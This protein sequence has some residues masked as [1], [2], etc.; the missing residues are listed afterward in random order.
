MEIPPSIELDGRQL[1]R[2]L[3][4][5]GFFRMLFD[6]LP[7][8][9]VV[10]ST[11]PESF[12]EFLLWNRVAEEW[13][14]FKAAD[15]IG[16]SDYDLFPKDCADFFLEM[17]RAVVASRQTLEIPE[18][19]ILSHTRGERYLHTI[20][21]PIFDDQG[22]PLALLVVSA[23]ITEKKRAITNLDKALLEMRNERN[24]FR[25]LLDNLPVCAFAKSARPESFGKYILWNR[26]AAELHGKSADEVLGQTSEDVYPSSL[27]KAAISQDE[28][29]LETR[30]PLDVPL[31]AVESK[32]HGTRWMHITKAPVFDDRGELV[33]IIG[34]SEDITE[35]M[36]SEAERARTT[37]VLRHL[38][39]RVPGAIYQFRM[40]A[41]GS[42]G[43][44][45][46]SERIEE[47]YGIPREE[48]LRDV[49]ASWHSVV[50]EDAPLVQ[51][52]LHAAQE[53]G[54]SFQCEF[55]IR[56]RD[57]SIRWV[58]SS[59]SPHKEAG[60]L[61][62]NGFIMDVTERKESEA[63][64]RERD[65][66]WELAL[67]G[68]EAGVWDW[69]I[70]TGELF[71][72]ERWKQLFGYESSELPA[73]PQ[74][75]LELIHPDD[76][77]EVRRGMLRHLRGRTEIFRSEYRMLTTSGNYVWILAHAK[78]HFG[79][80]GEPRRLIGT[81]IDITARKQAEQLLQIAK[82]AAEEA[83]RAKGNFLAMMSHEIRTPLN[84]VL[85]FAELLAETQLDEAQSEH[86]RTIRESGASL[87]RVL[88][89]ILDY[90]KIESGKLSIEKEEVDLRELVRSAVETF[91]VLA[92]EK[93]IS[94]TWTVA[95]DVPNVVTSDNLRLHQI[96][97][98]LVSNAVKF[99]QKGGV[100]VSLDLRAMQARGAALRFTISDTGIGIAEEHLPDLFNPFQQVDVSMARRFGG[101]GLGLTIVHRLVSML[102]GNIEVKSKVGE[103]TTFIVEVMLP[104]AA[105]P[106]DTQRLPSTRVAKS[107]GP[108]DLAILL[109]EDNVVN[110]RLARLMLER[111]G[112]QPDEAEDGAAAV[113]AAAR[114]RY[115]LILM[116]IQM[117]GMDGYQAAT[118][119][120]ANCNGHPPCIVALTA[121][122]MPSDRE[123]SAAHGM[124]YHITKPIRTNELRDVIAQCMQR[125]HETKVCN[126]PGSDKMPQ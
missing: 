77:E 37:E 71:Y 25:A 124:A 88:N 19:R 34:I 13:L 55:R 35:R 102:H 48:F 117:P 30:K 4:E 108:A 119:I 70:R 84:G 61:Y 41:D 74:A 33:A 69:N 31:Q 58:H 79:K 51:E 87:L 27:A 22:E 113:T 97:T 11:R 40:G 21:T 45:Y 94:L 2:I 125:R 122:A 96:L 29:V 92:Q 44:T 107:S 43:F 49:T 114:R 120:L 28:Q 57:G 53:S 39:S 90:S 17:D 46:V 56:H 106:G 62:W 126:P 8:Q 20:K 103:G 76:R 75:L 91:R 47:I 16:K 26:A 42:C 52:A 85:G 115:D 32:Q 86:V 110:R 10:K 66:R 60:A 63:A 65:E 98:N 3:N 36:S 93:N 50:P 89:D 112:H 18:E 118:Q 99:T 23:D 9:V 68:T 15:V 104:I 100:H 116:D 123:R 6:A 80:R 73:T 64:L 81:L 109:V 54:R 78:A 121:H 95:D 14:G 72:S 38:T 59:A 105:G 1:M 67:A 101:T 24:L 82:E 12:G 83:N 7:M 111:L 5:P